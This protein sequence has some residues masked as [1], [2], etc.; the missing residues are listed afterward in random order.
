MGEQAERLRQRPAR[1]RVGRIA[2]VK[3]RDRRFVVRRL[4][5]EEERRELRPGQQRLVHERLG[6][7]R[8]HEEGLELRAGSGDP[9]LDGAP[10][11]IQR[12]LPR[13]RIAPAVGRRGDDDLPD[14]RAGGPSR[15]SEDPGIDRHVAPPEDRH[16]FAREHLL[17]EG[18]RAPQG[19][20]VA[21]QEQRA[22]RE[23]LAG[24]ERE[25]KP[26]GL[27]VEQAVRDLGEHS[28]A[29]SRIV[30]GGRPPVR[31]ARQRLERQRED[32]VR[33]LARRARHESDPA[34]VLLP[35]GVEVRRAAVSPARPV[36]FAHALSSTEAEKEGPLGWE[37]AGGLVQSSARYAA[38][39]LPDGERGFA[40]VTT[41]GFR[42]LITSRPPKSI[43]RRQPVRVNYA[44]SS[45]NI[46][47]L[48][49]RCRCIASRGNQTG[50]VP[51]RDGEAV[52]SR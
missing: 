50:S 47:R 29:V 10:R 18:R 8:A 14:R 16:A 9:S 31:H 23:R 40:I 2:L 13:R 39:S 1:A 51:R 33:A 24:P 36:A 35:P 26:P 19:A 44:V 45:I 27:P 48:N 7:E 34:G 3:D 25:A 41:A 4:E 5:I 20:V 28:R 6:R 17:D 46:P 32:L 12:A 49:I 52:T 42:R 21:G 15:G 43:V 11:D 37:R 30:G 38:R 22:D